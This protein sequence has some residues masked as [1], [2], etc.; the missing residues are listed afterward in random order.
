[1]LP[2]VCSP[3]YICFCLTWTLLA[4]NVS[5]WEHSKI[6]SWAMPRFFGERVCCPRQ[7]YGTWHGMAW[8]GMV[9]LPYHPMCPFESSLLQNCFMGY[10]QI[11]FL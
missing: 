10:A 7:Y 11:F 8:F 1:M 5:S 6:V 3:D 4:S 9:C 2:E